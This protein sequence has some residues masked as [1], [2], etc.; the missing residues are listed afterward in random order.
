MNHNMMQTNQDQLLPLNSGEALQREIE[1]LRQLLAEKD[2]L[3]QSQKVLQQESIIVATEKVLHLPIDLEIET[4]TDKF[5]VSSRIEILYILRSMMRSKSLTTLTFG[6]DVILTTI[7]GVD[8]GR[9]EIIFDCG[10]DAAANLRAVKSKNLKASSLLSQVPIYF[11]CLDLNEIEFEGAGAFR[12]KFPKCLRRVQRRECFRTD[13]PGNVQ[14]KFKL[15][16]SEGVFSNTFIKN[17]SQGGMRVIG[18]SHEVPF[19][20]GVEYQGGLIDLTSVGIAKVSVQVR[21]V[22]EGTQRDGT[23]CLRAGLEFTS[24]TEQRAL[25]MI[26]QYLIKLKIEGQEL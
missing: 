14:L 19:E 16:I 20:I 15:P 7:I 22:S 4:V 1:Q 2:E 24:A 6:N 11:T 10:A 25:T 17:I 23:R 26:Q 12:A 21:S 13:I 18:P 3:I 5:L 9:R 8:V